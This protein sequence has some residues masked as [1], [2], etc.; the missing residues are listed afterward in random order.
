MYCKYCGK[1][2][3]G[4]GKFCSNCGK[5]VENNI[6]KETKAS[7]PKKKNKV[8]LGIFAVSVGVCIAIVCIV[9][10][11][12]EKTKKQTLAVSKQQDEKT[13][14]KHSTNQLI[15]VQSA[16]SGLWGYIN[17]KGEEAI[18]CQYVFHHEPAA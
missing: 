14:E 17:K 7:Q 4:N 2:I 5:P 8:T 15:P 9:F 12:S 10:G 1:E 18:A 6:K 11:V 13:K 3:R 16:E